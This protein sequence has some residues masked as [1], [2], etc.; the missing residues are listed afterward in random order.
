VES[1]PRVLIEA[2]AC[3]LPIIAT[4]VFGIPEL[5]KDGINADFYDPGN[6]GQLA[7]AIERLID[8]D[9]LRTDYGRNSPLVLASYPGYVEMIDRYTDIIRQAAALDSRTC[10]ES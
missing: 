4:P 7:G 3:S 6:I 10:V 5:V 8:D 2:M 1:A 9:A